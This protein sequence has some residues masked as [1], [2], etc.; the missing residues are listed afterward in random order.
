MC[1]LL[2]SVTAWGCPILGT[3]C[4]KHGAA[5]RQPEEVLLS[6]RTWD[7]VASCSFSLM[8]SL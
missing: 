3:R 4:V 5:E 8:L 7:M 2:A 1:P 6:S